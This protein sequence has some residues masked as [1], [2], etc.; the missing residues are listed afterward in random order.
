MDTTWG[1]VS[2]WCRP[3]SRR[4]WEVGEVHTPYLVGRAG[5][6]QKS[7]ALGIGRDLLFEAASPLV[8]DFPGSPEGL[9]DSLARSP[10]Q[11]IP[12]S[13]FGRFLASAQRG[14]FE[15]IKALLAEMNAGI[16]AVDLDRVLAL[17]PD[18]AVAM[19]PDAAPY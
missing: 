1:V 16:N 4:A 10:S 2:E 9:I 11:N 13:E 19:P 12:I 3:G 8:G 15:P 18:D 6:D 7:S 5:E 14:Y 17:Y